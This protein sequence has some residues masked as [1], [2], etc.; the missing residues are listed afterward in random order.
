MPAAYLQV[1]APDLRN[2]L[3]EAL[4]R[5]GI[6]VC[7]PEPADPSSLVLAIIE[8]SSERPV[9]RDL[10]PWLRDAGACPAI[11]VSCCSSEELVIAAL[12]M[13]FKEYLRAPIAEGDIQA[14]LTRFL[15]PAASAASAS[16][17]PTDAPMGT[18][19]G[20]PTGAAVVA[21]GI[22]GV[23]IAMRSLRD[24]IARVAAAKSGVLI[25]G[26]TGTGKELV[27]QAI[28]RLSPRHRKPFV[29]VNCAAIPDG[30]L[31]SELFG[32][33]RGAFTGATVAR[34]GRLQQSDGGTLF[35]DEIGE[36]DLRGQVK[37]LRVLEQRE[38][39]PLGGSGSRPLDLRVIAAT[40][41]PLAA[42]VADQSFR[43]D[44]FYR[45]KV[46]Q[47]DVPPLRERAED[48]PV[49][50]DHFSDIYRREFR[51]PFGAYSAHHHSLLLHYDWPGNIREL[52]N[53]LE[54]SFVHSSARTDARLELPPSLLTMLEKTAPLDERRQLLDALFVTRWNVSHAAKR[55]NCS[56]MTLYRKIHQY[57]LRRQRLTAA[58]M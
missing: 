28:H 7:H 57:Q 20:A 54:A 5:R 13:G 34:T 22:V 9:E 31:E 17:S 58:G 50:I 52:R 40:N 4:S 42:R 18:P 32:H 27:A 6:S 51:R 26:E 30:L 47:L 36:L 44:L 3:V 33:E 12:R 10:P 43:Q 21:P 11:A 25:T 41:Q 8:L 55:L 48:I 29:A 49:L 15:T 39:Q 23:S 1:R 53:V 46:V 38:V 14:A 2:V 19:T 24:Q 37:L 45:L 56:R 35:L 16:S